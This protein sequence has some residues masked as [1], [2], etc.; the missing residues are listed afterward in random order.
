MPGVEGDDIGAE[1]KNGILE[2][3]IPRREDLEASRGRRI[4]IQGD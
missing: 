1:L 3:T 2:V 4:D